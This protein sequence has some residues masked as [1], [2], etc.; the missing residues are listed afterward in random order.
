MWWRRCVSPVVGSTAT[1]GLPRWSCARC[2]PRFDG[3]FLFCCTAIFVALLGLFVFPEARQHGE[4]RFLA[5][6]VIPSPRLLD[7]R[8]LRDHRQREEDGV[9][10]QVPDVQG[11][12]RDQVIFRIAFLAD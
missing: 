2:M 12:I 3:D 11:L 5:A 4:R 7:P 1:G 9:L 6:A 10:D 8:L